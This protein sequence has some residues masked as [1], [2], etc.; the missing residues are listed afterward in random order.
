MLL[1]LDRKSGHRVG[2]VL[3][4]PAL[5]ELRE[6]LRRKGRAVS[7]SQLFGTVRAISHRWWDDP[8][9]DHEHR[10]TWADRPKVGAV[11]ATGAGAVINT[12]P[13]GAK[14]CRSRR[15]HDPVWLSPLGVPFSLSRPTRRRAS[16]L[17]RWPRPHS[18]QSRECAAR[19]A[20][21]KR[22]PRLR[23][24]RTLA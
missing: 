7:R 19:L 21:R 15:L 9:L 14:N 24:C 13:G 22:E 2:S 4:T 17:Q 3:S 5:Q 18:M 23:C 10:G 16:A 12:Y 11:Y 1:R 6:L 8:D 20:G